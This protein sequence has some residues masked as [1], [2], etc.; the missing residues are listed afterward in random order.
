MEFAASDRGLAALIRLRP[1]P[2]PNGDRA[3][4]EA[5]DAC[6]AGVLA[7]RDRISFGP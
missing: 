2:P 7:R 4:A 5:L 3:K 1:G 6:Y